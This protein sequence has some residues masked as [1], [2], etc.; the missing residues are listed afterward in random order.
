[1]QAHTDTGTHRHPNR[2]NKNVTKA[3]TTIKTH[4]NTVGVVSG[5]E[6]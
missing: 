4:E 1:M 3:P 2:V 6:A 5:R